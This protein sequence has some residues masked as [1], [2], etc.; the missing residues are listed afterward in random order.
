[1]IQLI[2]TIK[3]NQIPKVSNLSTIELI[4]NILFVFFI[5]R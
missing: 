3:I 4:G 5:E 1:M 2:C